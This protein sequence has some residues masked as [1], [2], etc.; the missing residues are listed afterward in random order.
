MVA[1]AYNPSTCEA[2]GGR[3][4][5]LR[6]AWSTEEVPEQPESQGETLSQKANKHN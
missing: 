4:L 6:P 1:H 2:E 5:S 3:S